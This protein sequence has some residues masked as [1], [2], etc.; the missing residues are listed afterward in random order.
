[1]EDKKIAFCVYKLANGQN[2]IGE[3]PLTEAEMA[4]YRKHPDTFFGVVK[5]G[6]RGGINDPPELYDY[7]MEIYQNTP[8]NGCWNFLAHEVLKVREI[9]AA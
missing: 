7:C 5:R 1:M 9:I 4:A 2:I 6:A 3:D 8:E